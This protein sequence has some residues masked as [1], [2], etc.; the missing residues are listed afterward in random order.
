VRKASRVLDFWFGARPSPDYGHPRKPWFEKSDAFDSDI[1]ER[2][3]NLQAQ[4]AAGRLDAWQASSKS[5]LALIVL[6]DQFPR[7]MHRG[8]P[9]AFACDPKAH[10]VARYAV[11]RGFDRVLLP[12]E[13]WFVYLPF[14]HAEDL[15]MQR[16]SLRLFAGL[17]FDPESAGAIDYARR[18]F[19]II[20]RFGR[21]PHR[22]DILG[23]ISSAD[24]T[25]FLG[26]PGSGF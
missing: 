12:V 14:E 7:N 17:G 21:F 20:A 5:A 1:H 3:S 25:E 16:E 11:S 24:E 6:L 9:K 13:R 15:A 23:R 22:N 26:Q 19:D 2:F 18:H 4:A 8:S 10:G